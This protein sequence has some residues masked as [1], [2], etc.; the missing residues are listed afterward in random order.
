MIAHRLCTASVTIGLEQGRLQT[1]GNTK[2]RKKLSQTPGLNEFCAL[3][4]THL[5]TPQ[6]DTNY[7]RAEQS[8]QAI[9]R[10]S[11]VLY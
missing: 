1:R 3:K 6:P 8:R 11:R 7:L 2:T 4:A 10:G 9:P 5:T